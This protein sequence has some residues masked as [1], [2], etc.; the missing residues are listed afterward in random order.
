MTPLSNTS[1]VNTPFALWNALM[2]IWAEGVIDRLSI[3]NIKPQKI[4]ILCHDAYAKH[5]LEQL[6]GILLRHYPDIHQIFLMSIEEE[7][8]IPITL[9]HCDTQDPRNCDL[10]IV[11][12]VLH[13]YYDIPGLLIQ[14][15][16][17][18]SHKGFCIMTLFGE[19]TLIE[20]K[21]AFASADLEHL[22]GLK[23]R[24]FPTITTKDAARLMQRAGFS[25]SISDIDRYRF[26][27]PSL[28]DLHQL[29]R[30][31][32]LNFVYN[33]NNSVFHQNGIS[34]DCLM[35]NLTRQYL[36]VVEKYYTQYKHENSKNGSISLD[37]I[38]ASAWK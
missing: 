30:H 28:T 19:D 33:N 29:L 32:H 15:N 10:I 24:F 17:L 37:M 9:K 6:A 11:T 1:S 20:L 26:S 34:N 8:N 21:R 4:A 14:L 25:D 13:K 16:H 35:K 23:Q 18:L 22:G 5:T 27:A 2:N 38:Y 36:S 7:P 31:S 3:L 12:P